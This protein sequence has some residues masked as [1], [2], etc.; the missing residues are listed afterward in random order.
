MSKRYELAVVIGRFQPLHNGHVNL[1]KRAREISDNI[2]VLV[3][4]SGQARSTVNPFTFEE[5]RDMINDELLRTTSH[6]GIYIEPL[7]N[8]LYDDS[9]WITQVVTTVN[10]VLY[11]AGCDPRAAPVALVG[12]DKDHTSYY[13]NYFPQ[14]DLIDMP[15]TP[16]SV[17]AT[18]IRKLLFE[19]DHAFIESVVPW[20]TQRFLGGWVSSQA[21]GQLV[22]EY[23]AIQAYKESWAGAP[24]PPMF[25]TVDSVVVQSGHVLLVKRKGYPGK[26]LWAM[27]GGFLNEHETIETGMIR[28]LREETGLKVPEKVLKGSIKH[29]GVFDH[30]GRSTRG[31][32]ITHAGLVKLDDREKLPRVRGQDDAEKAKWFSFHDVLG[33]R[34]QMFEDHYDIIESML[35]KI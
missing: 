31:R 29:V 11:S 10:R 34:D 20:A 2:L 17:D 14:W 1:L 13:L 4:S 18:K 33:M 23:E 21:H 27:P 7:V 25:V 8:T 3:G 9:R 35:T 19:E 28:E 30:P 22:L 6:D 24:F 15:P 5:R 16:V 12:H 32:T 26:G